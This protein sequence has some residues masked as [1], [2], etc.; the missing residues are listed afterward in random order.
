MKKLSWVIFAG[1]ILISAILR[2]WQLGAIP[3][4]FHADEADYGYNAYSLLKTGKDEYGKPYPLIYRSFGDYKGAVY[5]YLTIPFI[6]TSGLNEWA[7]RAPSAVFGILFTVLTFAFIY[8]ISKSYRLALLSMGIAAISP[9][10]ILLSRVQS[11]PLVGAFFFYLGFYLFLLWTEQKR[12]WCLPASVASLFIGFFTYSNDQ[13]FVIPFFLLLGMR[14]WNSWNKTIRVTTVVFLFVVSLTVAGIVVTSAGTRL[15]QVSIFSTMDVQLPLEEE[16]RED[17]PMK[18][19]LLVTRAFHNKVTA[20]GQYFLDNFASYLSYNFLFRQATQPM[21]EQIPNSGV[22]LLIDLPFLLIGIYTV[23]RKKYSYGITAVLWIFMVPM[24]LSMVSGE[25][26]NIHRFIWAAIPLYLLIAT[27][28]LA[29][30]DAVAK[31]YRI[32]FI[33]CVFILISLNEIIYL[34]RLFIHQPIHNPYNRNNPDK[35]LA[36]TLKR[37]APSYDVIV[38]QKILEH[39]LFFWPIDPLTYQKDGSPR[40][41]D[42]ARYGKFLFVTD[43]CPSNQQNPAVASLTEKRILYVDLAQCKEPLPVVVRIYYRNTLEA[44]RLV[45]RQ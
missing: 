23:F 19:P 42:N 45:E 16:I 33:L 35:E 9:L 18:I 31:R 20:Y 32:L 12:L 2:F 25:T 14:Y 10:G 24:V 11:D 38:T 8:C 40:D 41:T 3:D 28:L 37:L 4:G 30:Y 6:A 27:G 7:V 34:E 44:Y 22:L 36:L 26:P 15:G 29:A 5:A 21:R 1:I 39:M 13:L 43:A 17:G